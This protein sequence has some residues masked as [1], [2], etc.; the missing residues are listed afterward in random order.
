MKRFR[1]ERALGLMM[2]V[3]GFAGALLGSGCGPERAEDRMRELR[4]IVTYRERI[5]L[6]P[7]VRL[8][9]ELLDRTKAGATDEI[10]GRTV[11][12]NAGQV[13]IGFLITYNA[14]KFGEGRIYSVRASLSEGGR[15]LFSTAGPEAID[16]ENLDGLLEIV[17]RQPK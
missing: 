11:V 6:P 12:E 15:L 1:H 5:A 13:P 17:L 4:G 7:G 2:V 3:L 9:V 10:L 14:A 16:L 8:E